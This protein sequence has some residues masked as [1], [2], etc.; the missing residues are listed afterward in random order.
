MKFKQLNMINEKKE[1]T[2]VVNIS[3]NC[4]FTM[5]VNE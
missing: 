2:F 4:N 1:D 5:I 3:I